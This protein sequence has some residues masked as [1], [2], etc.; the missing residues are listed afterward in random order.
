MALP[1]RDGRAIPPLSHSRRD[2]TRHAMHYRKSKMPVMDGRWHEARRR[3]R[4][5]A[6]PLP[7]TRVAWTCWGGGMPPPARTTPILR[8]SRNMRYVMLL[9]RAGT[10]DLMH[11]S[12]RS[13]RDVRS[14]CGHWMT[15]RRTACGACP[16]GV[17][18]MQ[19]PYGFHTIVKDM[20]KSRTANAVRNDAIARISRRIGRD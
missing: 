18:H 11:S 5:V 7:A 13:P 12:W 9:A 2:L 10:N 3:W 14:S 17:G 20:Y 6:P 4:A 19:S 16:G 15:H 1:P 8:F